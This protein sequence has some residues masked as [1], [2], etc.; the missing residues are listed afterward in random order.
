MLMAKR[1]KEI[2]KE[3]WKGR[4]KEQLLF[5]GLKRGRNS[6]KE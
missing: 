1:G 2:P 3:Y 4:C 6:R 5:P